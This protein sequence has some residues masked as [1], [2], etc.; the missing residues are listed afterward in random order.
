[1][2]EMNTL[3]Q[4][5][6]RAIPV[7]G[8]YDIIVAGG[9]PAGCAAALA[10]ARQG[11]ST[12]LVEK[13][14]YLG[15]ATVSQLVSVVLSTNGADCQGVWHEFMRALQRRGG[16]SEIGRPSPNSIKHWDNDY[17]LSGTVTPEIAKYAWDDL[18]TTARVNLLHHV[19]VAG[20]ILEDTTITGIV[21]ETR[22]GRRAIRGKRVIDCTGDG[23]VAAQAGVAWDLG[24]GK[25]RYAMGNNK[26]FLLGNIKDRGFALSDDQ[27]G[28]IDHQRQAAV[29]RGEYTSPFITSGAVMTRLRGIGH[30]LP[31][32]PEAIM[33]SSRI[34]NVDPLDP[35]DITRAESE[36]R[37][38]AWQ[39]TDFFKRYVPGQ[40][41][42]YLASTSNHVG[43]RS[44][45]RIHG[46][47]TVTGA[48][49]VGFHKYPDG[50]ARGSWEIDIHPYNSHSGT[51]IPETAG[52]R[53]RIERLKAGDFY[54]IRYGCLVAT[55]VDN[56]MMA[57]R[58]ISAEFVAQGSLR[59]Q[60]T[61]M[62]TGQ[63]AGTA[64]ALSLHAETFPRELDPQL[65]V[66]QLAKDRD[67]IEPAFEFFKH[68]PLCAS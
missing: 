59:I 27:L 16:V 19:W 11:A 17:W 46:I 8:E 62:S 5:P 12:L 58:C 10:A 26:F 53:A 47:A 2:D 41:Q 7:M 13:E 48:D 32:R 6:P 42:V 67:S 21:V 49:T 39:V 24:D 30:M 65:V 61:C 1:M 57:G 45:R 25:S 37:E 34:I 64:A 9:G 29:E 15:G 28:E 55:G 33:S 38:H 50:I 52:Y 60:Q 3:Y 43:V 20:A 40:V 23:I 54:H 22:A 4:E 51:P 31:G 66:T 63:A 18:L 36:G 35:F 44:S 14:G 56:L 68:L